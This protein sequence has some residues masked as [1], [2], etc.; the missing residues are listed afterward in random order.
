MQW[1]V[2]TDKYEARDKQIVIIAQ[3]GATLLATMMQK[4]NTAGMSN[5]AINQLD[6][7]LICFIWA[8]INEVCQT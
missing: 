8:C 2:R 5:M 7:F 1:N 3:T 6:G 4:A